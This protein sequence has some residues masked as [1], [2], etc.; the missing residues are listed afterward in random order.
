MF[1]FSQIPRKKRTTTT[2][3]SLLDSPAN[4]G[5]IRDFESAGGE[6][7]LRLNILE[8][9]IIRIRYVVG[10]LLEAWPSYAV[11]PGYVSQPLSLEEQSNKTYHR[12]STGD[13]RITIDK[14]TLKLAFYSQHD[15][16][17]LQKDEH[18]FGY[19]INAWTGGKKNWV[20]K[21]IRPK[22]YFFG[23][24]D[25]PCDLNL[26]G[27]RLEMWGADHYAFHEHSDPLYK[28]IPFFLGLSEGSCYGIFYDNTART[29]FDFGA[30]E[31]N[32]LLFG[33]DR[34]MM[35]YYFIHAKS[36]IGII[37]AYTRLTGLPAMPPL[38]ALGYHQSKWSYYPEDTVIE[39]A[40]KLRTDS[41]PCDAIHLDIHHMDKYESFSW[42]PSMFPN[43]GQLINHLEEEG[44][45][46]VTI[47][48]PGI[49]IDHH[50]SIWRSGYQ[51][52]CF[53]RRHDGSLLE[54]VAWPGLC[55]FPDYTDPYVR[56]WW[57]DLFEHDVSRLGIRGIWADMNEPVIFPDK[58]FPED[59]RHFYDGRPCSHTKAHNVYGHCMAMATREGMLRFGG[60]RRPFV[61]TRSGYAGMQR[62]A[63]T[64]TGDNCSTWEHLKMA[65]FQ[66]QRLA[67]SGVSFAGS[68]TGGFLEHPSGELFCRWIQLAA[69]HVFFRNH[70]S[71]EYGGQEPWCFG[72]EIENYVRTAIEGRYRLL[73]YF[74][75]QFYLFA[76]KGLPI[77]RSL[78]LQC[79]HDPDTYW[80]GV[81]FFVGEHMYVVPVLN[82][83]TGGCSL[84]V[85]PGHWYSYRDD[86]SL[87]GVKSDSWLSCDLS[88]IPV[89][90]RGG[91]VIPHWPVQQFVGEFERPDSLLDLWWAPHTECESHLY[92]DSGD[93][94]E[95]LEGNFTFSTF[96]YRS[97]ADGF[98]L[99]RHREGEGS[100]FHASQT[101]LVHALPSIAGELGCE[102]DGIP[103]PVA[104][105]QNGVA[106][107]T[108]PENFSELTLSWKPSAKDGDHA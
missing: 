38:W 41:I 67:A 95:H 21:T 84:Y 12:I 100:G 22:E 59:T 69:F 108:L 55:N 61:L 6:Y 19:E 17:L 72:E 83:Q 28:N 16:K 13:L 48:N 46:T 70:S 1:S 92:E 47:V 39:L 101:L 86:A 91:A 58:T 85:P 87:D 40:D 82:P 37:A 11:D 88:T 75:T 8:S 56:D 102:I 53:C 52:N 63:A 29:Y 14:E 98:K 33:A 23:L 15:G 51:F 105:R 18:G 89:F 94:F 103:V 30:T 32:I 68:D 73:P 66:C 26:R 74:Y 5:E 45:K 24:G 81:E 4:G 44:I 2:A 9:G 104:H 36:P 62:F 27:R 35:D 20:R 78:P 93:G 54:G 43:P 96:S 10:N 71:G 79:Y 76:K 106:A 77:I 64:W 107:I 97:E 65:N 25:K 90:V 49:K 80:R 60:N 57:A 7:S 34:G 99:I 50:A 3:A 31:E 42:D